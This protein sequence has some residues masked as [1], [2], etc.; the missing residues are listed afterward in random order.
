MPDEI[1]LTVDEFDEIIQPSTRAQAVASY[2]WRR[3]SGGIVF[4]PQRDLILSH[5]RSD[6]KDERPGVWVST[7]GGKVRD[8]EGVADAA[9]RE[10]SEEFGLQIIDAD[11]H[12]VRK[13]RAVSRFQFEY[14]HVVLIDSQNATVIPDHTEVAEYAWIPGDDLLRKINEQDWFK[15]GYELALLEFARR[16]GVKASESHMRADGG[17]IQAI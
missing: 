8:G 1:V 6:E 17:A 10:L 4:D 16:Q 2:C 5:R 15:Y 9:R 14:L 11:L 12:F 13:E 3:A 7:F